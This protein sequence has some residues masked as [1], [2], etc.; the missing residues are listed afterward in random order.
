MLHAGLP[1]YGA[2]V[3]DSSAFQVYNNITENAD[4]TKAVK[5]TKGELLYYGEELA[6]AYYYSTS[7]GKERLRV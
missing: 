2:H 3:D 1:T 5:E 4:T 6:E 7:C